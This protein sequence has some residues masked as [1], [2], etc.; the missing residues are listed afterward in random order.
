VGETTI[1]WCEK[2]WNPVRGCLRVSPGCG[3]GTSGRDEGRAGGCYAEKTAARFCG[4]GQPYEGLVMIGVN[5]ARW[6]GVG[7][8]VPEKLDEPLRW[9]RPTRV[10]V[11]SMSDLFFNEFSNED[12]AAIF[13]VMMAAQHHTFLPLT[14]RSKRMREWYAWV[15]RTAVNH[16]TSV[17]GLLLHHAQRLCDH[18][19]LRQCDRV[20]AARWPLPNVHLGVSVEDQKRAEERIPDLLACPAVV[21]WLS[22]EP[23][24]ED[25]ELNPHWLGGICTVCSRKP[26][27]HSTNECPAGML[28]PGIS[29]I[30]QGGESG[31]GARAFNPVW[32]RNLRR[33][34]MAA[35]DCRYFFKQFGSNVLSLNGTKLKDLHGGDPNEW[36]E[37]FRVRE[38]PQEAS[39]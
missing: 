3:G 27:D 19:S 24:L 16:N 39:R 21:R 34:C 20:L 7:R 5:G 8:V 30:V 22:V 15:E 10:F 38:Y 29:W 37:E 6:T 32:A 9:R 18:R 33:Q 11:N 35:D 4:P 14:K 36:P 26:T 17:Q 1:Q 25:I 31:P 23:Q 28:R 13:G 2:V 12:I